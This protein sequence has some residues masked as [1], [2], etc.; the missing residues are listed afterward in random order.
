MG[1]SSKWLLGVEGIRALY[2]YSISWY[3]HSIIYGLSPHG[4]GHPVIVLPGLGTTDRSTQFI[5]HYID[6]IGYESFSWGMGRNLGPRQGFDPLIQDLVARI[7]KIY[8]ISGNRQVSIIGWSL[9]GIYAR[10]IAKKCPD[11]VRQVITL[12]TP[13]KDASNGTNI[14][15]LYEILSKDKSHKNATLVKR[16][17]QKPPVPFTSIYSKTDGVVHWESSLEEETSISEKIEIPNA[18]HL[19]LGHNPFTMLVIAN[20]LLQ[21]KENWKLYNDKL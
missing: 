7:E 6:E 15:L 12:G 11:K 2:E 10:E 16:I 1:L 17:A 5:R 21:S 13:F 8:E 19:G 20:R 3:L 9:G 18:S 14:K 4:D